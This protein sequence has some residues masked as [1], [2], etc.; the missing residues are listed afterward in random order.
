MPAWAFPQK[1]SLHQFTICNELGALG[2]RASRSP[3][4][5][6]RRPS[7]GQISPSKQRRSTDL[8]FYEEHIIQQNTIAARCSCYSDSL[9]LPAT[10]VAS[11]ISAL[12]RWVWKAA[13]G[14]FTRRPRRSR[15]QE[16]SPYSKR[17]RPSFGQISPS[18]Q[19]R[20]TDLDF[21]EEHIIQQNTIAARC[22][23]YSDSLLLPA[24]RVASAISALPRWV[25]KAAY[26]TFTR[27]PRRSRPQERPPC[28]KC[29]RRRLG[30]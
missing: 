21:Y 13:Y 23:C 10:R 6:R 24:T 8:D 28:K 7:F 25:W 20:S 3:Y 1:H 14:T 29:R 16:R 12:P 22:S 5:K 26:G 18:K 27:R 2:A 11:A 19:R 15:P 17:R 30:K 9:L 4:S